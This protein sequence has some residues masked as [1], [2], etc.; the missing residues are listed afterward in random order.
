MSPSARAPA[1]SRSPT[2]KWRVFDV[3]E[4]ADD[5][6]EGEG[7]NERLAAFAVSAAIH[8][9]TTKGWEAFE[10]QVQPTDGSDANR[11]SVIRGE[12]PSVDR[13]RSAQT[14]TDSCPAHTPT[15]SK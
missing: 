10:F 5:D 11:C 4:I 1:I 15:I 13:R 8:L 12:S 6:D 3:V 7:F 2:A 14:I 9:A